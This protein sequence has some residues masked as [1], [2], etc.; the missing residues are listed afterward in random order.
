MLQRHGASIIIIVRVGCAIA[1]AIVAPVAIIVIARFFVATLASGVLIVIVTVV[2][3]I[4]IPSSRIA[5]CELS[6]Q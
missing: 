4:T 6:H 1:L 5:C 2:K 3:L